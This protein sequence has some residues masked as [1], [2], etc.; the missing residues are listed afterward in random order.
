MT[1]QDKQI[2]K[3]EEL[4][5]FL[6]KAEFGTNRVYQ[7]HRQLGGVFIDASFQDKEETSWLYQHR[8][9]IPEPQLIYSKLE[10]DENNYPY[11]FETW[12]IGDL[13]VEVPFY[14]GIGKPL[15][16]FLDEVIE[17]HRFDSDALFPE[18][19]RASF[20]RITC[21]VNNLYDYICAELD[22]PGLS[23]AEQEAVN[24]A[25]NEANLFEAP[26]LNEG[27]KEYFFALVRQDSKRY[28]EKVADAHRERE[29]AFREAETWIIRKHT[30]ELEKHGFRKG[31]VS[32]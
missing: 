26:D 23:K 32:G 24:T 6:E 2:H 9:E 27:Y 10:W 12:R 5:V 25:F 29:S 30:M 1:L 15:Y 13:K 31:F 21:T 14:R 17:V 16:D 8:I 7:L 18:R 3:V 19:V 4:S 28:S 11:T 20:R 22:G